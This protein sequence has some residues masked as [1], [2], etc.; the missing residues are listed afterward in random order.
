[1][2][3]DTSEIYWG[4]PL[5]G[6]TVNSLKGPDRL[7]VSVASCEISWNCDPIRFKFVQTLPGGTGTLSLDSTTPT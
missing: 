5:F 2:L 1:M 6:P 7:F 3:K 4:R